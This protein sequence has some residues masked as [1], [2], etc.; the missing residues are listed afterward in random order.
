[1]DNKDNNAKRNLNICC[2]VFSA[3]GAIFAFFIPF[4]AYITA[5]T[6]LFLNTGNNNKKLSAVIIGCNAAVIIIALICHMKQ[7]AALN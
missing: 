2:F 6:S 3:I 7:L 4:I 1:M 5:G